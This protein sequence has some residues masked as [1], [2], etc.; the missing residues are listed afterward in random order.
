[1]AAQTIQLTPKLGEEN[2]VV[3]VEMETLSKDLSRRLAQSVKIKNTFELTDDCDKLN[4]FVARVRTE[5]DELQKSR[6]R[7][8]RGIGARVSRLCAN[9]SRLLTHYAGIAELIKSMDSRAGPLAYGALAVSLSVCANLFH[10]TLQ[11]SLSL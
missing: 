6:R 7:R 5:H 9:M 3:K 2:G 4:D 11:S 8:K 1:M 10:T